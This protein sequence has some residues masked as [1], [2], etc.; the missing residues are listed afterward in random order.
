MAMLILEYLNGYVMAI[1]ML[2]VAVA[3]CAHKPPYTKR[4]QARL[5]AATWLGIAV[6]YAA[7]EAGAFDTADG[8]RAALR[9]GVLLIG[10]STLAYYQN[11]LADLALLLH[12]RAHIRWLAVWRRHEH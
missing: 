6:A 5:N 11:D 4:H 10:L 7:T 3:L 1:I 9:V 2:L 12:R 8:E